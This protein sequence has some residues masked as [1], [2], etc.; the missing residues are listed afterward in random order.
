MILRI[1]A[2]VL[3]IQTLVSGGTEAIRSGSQI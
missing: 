2:L 3:P 1:Q